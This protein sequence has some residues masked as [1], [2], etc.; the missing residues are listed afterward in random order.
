MPIQR[1]PPLARLNEPSFTAR[2]RAPPPEPAAPWD[3]CPFT[4]RPPA[5][6]RRPRGTQ[7]VPCDAPPLWYDAR[8]DTPRILRPHL[9]LGDICRIAVDVIAAGSYVYEQSFGLVIGG[10]EGQVVDLLVE[11]R[12]I[13][14]NR[15]WLEPLAR[16]HVRPAGGV[17]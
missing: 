8:M 12:L 4:A 5:A 10:I 11:G 15:R 17:V 9:E 1:A 16:E 7:A 2:I 14:L 3:E 13:K 6:L